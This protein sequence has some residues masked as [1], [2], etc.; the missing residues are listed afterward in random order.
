MSAAPKPYARRIADTHQ[1]PAALRELPYW[2]AWRLVQKP[3][4]PKPD[5]I[6]ISP[7]TGK[8]N[9]SIGA[10]FCTDFETARDYAE[11][12]GL[13][14]VGLLLVK[15]C[16]LGG[17]DLDHC[18][19]PQTGEL[20]ELAQ[21]I[22]DEA[23]TYFEVS[24][25]LS[26]VR[27]FFFG[28]FGGYIGNNH[29]AGV[30]FY[31]DDGARFLTVTGDHLEETPFAI[32]TRDL[33]E[34][35]ALYHGRKAKKETTDPP[36][37][38]DSAPHIDLDAYRL[39]EFTKR[40]IR[41]GDTRAYHGDRSAALF[42]LAK[43]LLKAGISDETAAR[44]LCDPDNGISEK[45]LSERN[46]DWSSALDWMLKYTIPKARAA[47]NDE[48]TV[49]DHPSDEPEESKI[50]R[51]DMGRLG[52]AEL[53]PPSFVIRPILPRKHLTLFGAHGGSGKTTLALV[54]AAHVA[55]GEPWADLE[56]H[57][58]RV[59][60]VSFEDDEDLIL[61]R[62]Q[63]IA[64]QYALPLETIR[65]AL[66]VLDATE[67]Q[68]MMGEF[69][70]YGIKRALPSQDGK[71]IHAF[72]TKEQF[73]L[74][75]IDNASDAY[76]AD[77]ISRRSTRQFIRWLAKSVQG[78]GGAVLLLAHIDKASAKFGSNGNSYSG[79]TAWHNTARS[80]L[81]L[82]NDE[83]HQEKLNVGK[84]LEQPI[85]LVWRDPGVPVP[86]ERSSASMAQTMID[87]TNDKAVL[88]AMHAAIEAGDTI[89]TARTGP[90]T[91]WHILRSYPELPETMRDKSGKRAFDE[92]LTRLQRAGEITR[93]TFT[94]RHR[95]SREK[96]ICVNARQ[97]ASMCVE[98][99]DALTHDAPKSAC[100]NAQ[101]VWGIN[102]RT[103]TNA[104]TPP[105]VD[106]RAVFGTNAE[107]KTNA[108]TQRIIDLSGT[109]Q[110]DASK[111]ILTAVTKGQLLRDRDTYRLPAQSEVSA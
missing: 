2:V 73:D 109:S 66:T 78:H 23:D 14:G 95:N 92:S 110:L 45:A 82:V 50:R 97:C 105:L 42:G 15:D 48:R 68:P 62:L 40:V 102:E 33:S 98:D 87:A 19:D 100:V 52:T 74:V 17:I 79:S 99:I 29:E 59:L 38:E 103:Q 31:E 16:G 81:A 13:Q 35:G 90:A 106:L 77:E 70:E 60:F 43:D 44:I 56:T 46:G 76:D 101:G 55:C 91:A 27:G 21:G 94:D 18:R 57:S 93:E 1:I 37:R 84:K 53:A 5:K 107:L 32:E 75:I 67:A 85:P 51:C 28:G 47:V 24:P 108:L 25:G 30:E 9:W 22:V 104:P 54:L 80:R 3:G 61:W 58:G 41:T 111:F 26:G 4:K 49:A 39:G 89:P 34:L 83:L 6:P 64:H 8:S 71:H 96:W 63:N 10:E 7:K 20:S 69:S 72:I 86:S 11:R 65:D 12:N 88:G 36:R